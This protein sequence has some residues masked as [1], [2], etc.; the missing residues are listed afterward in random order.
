VEDFMA[1]SAWIISAVLIIIS[2]VTFATGVNGVPAEPIEALAFPCSDGSNYTVIVSKRIAIYDEA[3]PYKRQFYGF[4]TSDLANPQN[5][6]QTAV[7]ACLAQHSGLQQCIQEFA[8]LGNLT[9]QTDYSSGQ[10]VDLYFSPEKF[11]TSP[12]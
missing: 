6:T 11:K 4:C 5:L 12:R 1:K 10:G 2:P 3:G 8:R 9:Y 7:A